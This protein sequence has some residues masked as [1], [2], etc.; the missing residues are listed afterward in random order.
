[1]F[2]H[3]GAELPTDPRPPC[4]THLGSRPWQCSQKHCFLHQ[5]ASPQR[6]LLLRNEFMCMT[7]NQNIV[8]NEVQ[9][10]HGG[11]NGMPICSVLLSPTL[12]PGGSGAFYRSFCVKPAPGLAWTCPFSSSRRSSRVAQGGRV[13]SHL[14]LCKC[15]SEEAKGQPRLTQE[16]MS[17]TR[18][19]GLT[20][21]LSS[22]FQLQQNCTT[23]LT[24]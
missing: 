7:H 12:W 15:I 6:Q 19:K 22:K 11:K 4:R 10:G 23:C 24:L 9:K 16:P 1:M 5:N 13:A 18:E 3:E 8:E 2:F 14:T 21:P 20:C 17:R